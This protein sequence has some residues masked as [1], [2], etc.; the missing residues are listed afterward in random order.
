MA[1]Y[2][3]NNHANIKMM[4]EKNMKQHE[5]VLDI[6]SEKNWLQMVCTIQTLIYK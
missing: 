2:R 3:G 6:W 4:I 5:N 1:L